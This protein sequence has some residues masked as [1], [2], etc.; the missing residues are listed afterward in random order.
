VS[1]QT[2]GVAVTVPRR[3]QAERRAS[4]RA[5]LLDAA[6]ECLA[7]LGYARTTTVEVARR[8]GVSRGAQLH[9]F[10]TKA[11]LVLSA[12]QHVIER[13]EVAFDEAMASVPRGP[14]RP[15][16][17]IDVLWTMFT[18]PTFAA[19]LELAVAA[20]TDP[21]LRVGLHAVEAQF[22]ATVRARFLEV[23]EAGPDAGDFFEVAPLFTFALLDGVALHRVVAADPERDTAA[24]LDAFKVVARLVAPVT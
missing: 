24:L 11:E 2:F 19:W 18:G 22:Q 17:A 5:R 12:M 20:R 3:T 6:V 21:E 14:G 10:P 9:H 1:A 8:A 4:T 23:F 13:Q 7:E 16:A 15:E